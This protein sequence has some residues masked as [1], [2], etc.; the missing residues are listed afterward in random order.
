M[1]N[2]LPKRVKIGTFWQDIFYENLPMM[3][4]R[5][6]RIG[7]R[8][9]QCLEAMAEPTNLS[10]QESDPQTPAAPLLDPN[11]VLTPWKTVH[12][13]RTRARGRPTENPHRG[14]SALAESYPPSHPR[15]PPISPHAHEHRNHQIGS[16]TRQECE[17][18][19]RP[20][21][22][23]YDEVASQDANSHLLQ[24]REDEKECMHTPCKAGCPSLRFQLSDVPLVGLQTPYMASCSHPVNPTSHVH[25]M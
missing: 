10:S 7:H 5:C 14:K 6:G 25:G 8:E 9:P 19:T 13:R 18:A 11:H 1:T 2:P 17:G 24:P 22:F 20:A 16:V 15:G 3:C 12:T 23:H 4:Y 21:G